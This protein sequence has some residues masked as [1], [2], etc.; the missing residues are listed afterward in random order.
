MEYTY[1]G[2]RHISNGQGL[3][4]MSGDPLVDRDARC[5]ILAASTPDF[6]AIEDSVLS[7]C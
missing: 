5:E 2:Y 1:T 4:E 3:L 7:S 6:Q